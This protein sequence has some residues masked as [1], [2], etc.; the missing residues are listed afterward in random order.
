[1]K[2]LID[3][4]HPAHVHYFRNFAKEM[5]LKG[6]QILFTC[7]NK[8]MTIAL[9]KH[10]NLSFISFG[11]PYKSVP[12]KLFGLF[13]FTFRVLI[14]AI[15]FK[16]D[17]LLNASMYSAITAWLLRKPH[18]SFEDT[19]NMEQIRLY[20]PFTSCIFTGDY[21]HPA[22]GVKEIIFSGYQELLYLHP[23][24]F[25]PD[26]SVLQEL[27]VS[28]DEKYVILRFV[29]W[30]ASHDIGHKG[31]TYENKLKA[32]NE[33]SKFAKVFISSESKL[34]NELKKYQI[35]IAPYKMHDALAFA[36]LHWAES[37]TM[38]A[39]C[40]V[41]GTPSVVI[42]NTKSYYLSEQQEK[43]GLCYCYSESDIDQQ[44][45][46]EKGLEL[47]QVSGVKEEWKRRRDKMLTDKIDVT[48]FLVWF[49]ENYPESKRIMQENPDYQYNF[50]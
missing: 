26:N 42:H 9:L 7:R 41:L 27:G 14:V 49:V 36:A 45:A 11:K 20:R 5:T 24:R 47:L 23:N 12:G 48:A 46:I 44:K 17:I 25:A 6:H 39:E 40:S 33:F 32:V 4:G 31:I 2:Y 43:Y 1:M 35:K 15:K 19:F 50:K 28:V 37:F 10:Y 3:I 34:P 38:P 21:E 13:Y 22:L 30:N 16:P 18:F 8:E 29:S